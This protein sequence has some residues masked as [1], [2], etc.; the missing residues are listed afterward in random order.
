ME[1]LNTESLEHAVLNQIETD[2]LDKDFDAYSEMMQLLLKNKENRKIL[3]DY[4]LDTAQENVKLGMTF[5]RY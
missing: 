5:S 2:L 1:N 3:F 4:L